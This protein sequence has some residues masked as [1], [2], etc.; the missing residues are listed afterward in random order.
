MLREFESSRWFERSVSE[1]PQ[2]RAAMRALA[3]L[4]LDQREVIVLKIW[5][6]CTFEADWKI[7]GDIT[8]HRGGTLPL[9]A[10]EAQK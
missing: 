8:Q 1:T 4:P 10:A 2:E 3:D 6:Q 9:R 5:H 7:A